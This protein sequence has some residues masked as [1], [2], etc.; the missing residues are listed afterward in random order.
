MNRLEKIETYL[1]DLDGTFYLGSN[2]YPWSLPFV[3]TM[4]RLGKRF[5]FVTNNSSQNGKYYLEKIRKMGVDI[6]EDQIFTSGQATIFYLKKYN[7][8]KKLY[9]V[10]TPALEEEFKEAGFILTDED[11][12]TVVLGFDMT[13]TYEKLRT[14]CDLIRSGVPFIATHPDFNCPTPEGPIPDCG[15]MI[16]LITASTGV[17]PKI[18]GKPYPEMIEALQAKYGLEN[19][20]TIAMVGDRLYTDLA[21][22][23]AAGIVGILVLSGETQR[24]DLEDSEVQPDLVLENLGEITKAL[25]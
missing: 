3:E 5:V 1:L 19:P 4:R 13:L 25:S 24:E 22:A 7:Y 16:A 6:T 18:I 9:L 8:P 14:A 20:D 10:G 12:E 15:A 21:M 23:K 2:L 11:P 17:K